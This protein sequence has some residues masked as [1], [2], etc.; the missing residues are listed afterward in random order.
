LPLWYSRPSREVELTWTTG[1]GVGLI[2]YNIYRSRVTGGPYQKIFSGWPSSPYFDADVA[3]G[4]T[5]FYVV[6]STDG[7]NESSKTSEVSATP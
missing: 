7:V 1:S 4:L 2:G 6:S 3:V 5:Y